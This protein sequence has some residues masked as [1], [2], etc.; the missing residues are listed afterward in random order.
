LAG[1]TTAVRGETWGYNDLQRDNE[2]FMS[3]MS[4]RSQAACIEASANGDWRLIYGEGSA[5]KFSADELVTI[6][7]T[8]STDKIRIE[9]L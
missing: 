7:D 5:R 2:E 8:A 6:L 9:E 1:V 3:S 4:S